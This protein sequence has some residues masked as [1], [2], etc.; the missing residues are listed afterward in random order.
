MG[1]INQL[2]TVGD[3]ICIAYICGDICMMDER[4]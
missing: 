3:T 4:I 2:I 1:V